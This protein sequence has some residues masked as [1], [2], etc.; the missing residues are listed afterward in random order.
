MDVSAPKGVFSQLSLHLFAKG[1]T[2]PRTDL[3]K[4]WFRWSNNYPSMEVGLDFSIVFSVLCE[5]VSHN[6][7]GEKIGHEVLSR[8]DPL[9]RSWGHGCIGLCSSSVFA[10]SIEVRCGCPSPRRENVWPF[11]ISLCVFMFSGSRADRNVGQRESDYSCL[12]CWI[13]LRRKGVKLEASQTN[14]S[15]LASH[16]ILKLIYK[17]FETFAHDFQWNDVVSQAE[18]RF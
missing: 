16:L 1:S 12:F 3:P 13:G 4:L 6:R 11:Q 14:L 2:Q 15:K 10:F 7:P 5:R 9:V 17:R 18:N 8:P